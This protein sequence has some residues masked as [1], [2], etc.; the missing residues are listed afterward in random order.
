MATKLSDAK[1]AAPKTRKTTTGVTKKKAPAR[2]A[3]KAAPVAAAPAPVAMP[4]LVVKPAV[5]TLKLKALVEQV[6]AATGARKNGLKETIEATLAIIGKALSEGQ[7]LNLPPLGKARVGRQK[8]AG[9]GEMLVI[10]LKRGGGEKTAKKD[11]VE[12]V[13]ATED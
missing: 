12:G 13:A 2:P 9:T 3:P 7:E 10:K 8:E 1:P 5:P 6:A 4:E 11:A